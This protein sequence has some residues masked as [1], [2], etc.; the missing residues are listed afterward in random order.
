MLWLVKVALRKPYTVAVMA[1]LIFVMGLL[2]IETTPT[3][4]FPD[5]DIPVVNVVWF[6]QGLTPED[7]TNFITTFSEFNLSQYVD[8]VARMESRTYYGLNLIRMYFQPGVPIDLAVSEA[9]SI[10]QTVIKRMPLGTTPPYVLR[11]SAAEVPVIQLAVSG[12][13]KSGADLFDYTWYI[14]RRELATIRGATFPPPWGGTA[15]FIRVDAYPDQLLARGITAQEL[16]EVINNQ[17][18]DYASG[19]I[20]I[21]DRDYLVSV[22]NMPTNVQEMNEIPIKKVNGQIVYMHDLGY[23]R[24]GGAV[25]WNFA[26]YNGVPA[27]IMPLLKN[28]MAS[29]LELVANLKKLLPVAKA[30]APEG[31]EIQELMDQSVFVRA[32]VEGVVKEGLIAAG[33]TGVMILVFLGSW[34][35]TLIV[36]TSIPLCI[37]VALFILSRMGNTINIMT[38]G[39]LALAV[40]ILVDD[41]TVEVE[42]IHRNHGMGKPLIQAIL[43]GAQQIANAAFVATLSI[44]IVF[45]SVIFLEGP[46]KYLF[47]PMALGV[48]FSMLF[49]Y[50]LSRTLVPTMANMLIR[51]EELIEHKRKIEGKALSRFMR[52]HH[53]FMDRFEQFRDNYGEL[54]RWSLHH[55]GSVFLLFGILGLAS[56]IALPFVG[57]NFF[58]PVDAGK[59]RLHVFAPPGTRLETTARI[60]SEIEEY[61]K[62]EIVPEEEIDSIVDLGGLPFWFPAGMAFGDY[63][64]EGT[65]D[66]EILVSLKE[67]HH[68]TSIYVRKIRE[69]LPK[70]FPG[71]EFFFQ[72]PDM[73]NQILNFGSAAPIDIQVVGKDPEITSRFAKE[74]QKKVKKVK[75]AADVII[76]QKKQPYLHLKIDRVRAL[77]FGL[78]QR[79]IANNILNQLSSSYVVAP[80][81]WADPKTTINYPLVIQTPQHLIDSHNSLLNINLHPIRE[82]YSDLLAAREET[83]LL[84]NVVTVEHRQKAAVVSHYNVKPIYNVFVNVQ[85]RDLGGV[86][87]D[88]QKIINDVKKKLPPAYEI[89]IRGQ[90]ESMQNAFGRL[91]LGIIF[92][93]LMVYFLLV[94]N[95]QGW[96]DP[97]IILMALPAGFC[98]VIWMLYLTG[99]TF[100]VP[101]LMGMIMTVGVATSNSIL[102]ITFANEE[103]R[104][105]ADAV[106]AAW[107]A[108]RIRLRPVLMTAGAMILGMLPMS[109]GLGEGGEQNAPLG[110]AVIGGMIFA[111]VGTLF[112]VP[113]VFSII[114]GRKT[115]H[116]E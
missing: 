103:M 37:L 27:V 62:K 92:A 65:F 32:S 105:G 112:F 76:Y 22:N 7:M 89:H 83:Q 74:I 98:G 84:S 71:C 78:N 106:T 19:D 115:S 40:G 70:Q 60:F 35:S 5:I 87:S 15:R 44:C 55:K 93:I 4:I 67:D 25:Q 42:N 116:V 69:K 81:Y 57:E 6:Y 2:T 24:D 58:P 59:F 63:I 26:R 96:V 72:P 21:G 66:G 12:K 100:S 30:S 17:V 46:P 75:G 95:F 53:W 68:P 3:D 64:N 18:L 107:M 88:V 39:G 108:G 56:F 102:L 111:T 14:F 29:T 80:N 90:A 52:F 101:S 45:T 20:K 10:C 82:S 38:L 13:T 114:R 50:F 97:F 28:G 99:T 110:R 91:G 41:A 94:V 54:L 73:V 33:L 31:I 36:L 85:G 79:E 16:M 11:Y 61:I 51:Q 86:V 34:R 9:V 109:L 43:D 113:V 104:N 23:V 77:D 49:S 8:N 48:V 1:A 47:T